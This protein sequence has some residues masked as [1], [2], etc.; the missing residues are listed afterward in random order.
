LYLEIHESAIFSNLIGFK[1]IIYK[2]LKT[3]KVVLDFSNSVYIDHSF[4][5]YLVYLQNES[6]KNTIEIIGIENLQ[7]FTNHPESARKKK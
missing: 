6:A 7:P 4:M 2:H 3:G 5:S 1:K